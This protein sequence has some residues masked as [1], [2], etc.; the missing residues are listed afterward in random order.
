[1]MKC[2]TLNWCLCGYLLSTRDILQLL[3]LMAGLSE[4][5][6]WMVGWKPWKIY[7]TMCLLGQTVSYRKLIGVTDGRP[8]SH[9][10]TPNPCWQ[11]NHGTVPK[12]CSWLNFVKL[13]MSSGKLWTNYRQTLD[14]FRGNFGQALDKRWTCFGYV[15]AAWVYLRSR[16]GQGLGISLFLMEIFSQHFLTCALPLNYPSRD[17]RHI[18]SLGLI[19]WCNPEGQSS[20]KSE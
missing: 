10:A 1:M 18:S 6:K 13:R 5:D 4:Q 19:S 8:L 20:T 7:T 2:N 16:F 9:H 11:T 14:K 17:C 3:F 12:T 15:W